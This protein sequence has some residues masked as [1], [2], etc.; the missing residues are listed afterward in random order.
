MLE[1]EAT[2]IVFKTWDRNFQRQSLKNC[3]QAILCKSLQTKRNAAIDQ[4][5]NFT[6]RAFST[7]RAAQFPTKE[8]LSIKSPNKYVIC[9]LH[10][11]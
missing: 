7:S 8:H 4:Q 2:W 5:S 11:S 3:V 10:K 9:A 1:M 6:L